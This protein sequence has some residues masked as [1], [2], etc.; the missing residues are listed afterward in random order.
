VFTE[1]S[2]LSEKNPN[3]AKK[4]LRQRDNVV[5]PWSGWENFTSEELESFV[6]QVNDRALRQFDEISKEKM[7][8]ERPLSGEEQ[9]LFVLAQELFEVSKQALKGEVDEGRLKKANQQ[10]LE[11]KYP[12]HL[13]D[14]SLR[15]RHGFISNQTLENMLRDTN[16]TKLRDYLNR[17]IVQSRV[18]IDFLTGGKET[19]V[20]KLVDVG[21]A[22]LID[23]SYD[24]KKIRVR[25][26]YPLLNVIFIGKTAEWELVFMNLIGNALKAVEAVSQLRH[27]FIDVDF[28]IDPK[29]KT[30]FITIED[31]GA[32]IPQRLLES[33][34][35]FRGV[36]GFKKQGIGGTGVGL[37]HIKEIIESYNGEIKIESQ[38]G[39]RT[40]VIIELPLK[41]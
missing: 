17:I 23:L 7:N 9:E 11:L 5:F 15:L 26:S 3:A 12:H 4:L 40:K 35:I 31:N 2:R 28:F 30:F 33:G 21:L 36:S 10:A 13:E 22:L 34:A 18:I 32:G 6:T 27:G 1:A 14:L 39:L 37:P 41:T 38:E 24:N 29:K 19:S 8:Q 25:C 20:I 16:K